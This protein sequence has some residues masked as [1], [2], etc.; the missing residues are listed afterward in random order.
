[1]GIIQDGVWSPASPFFDPKIATTPFDLA[2]ANAL[3]DQAGWKRTGDATRTKNG[4]PL[5]IE[6][7]SNTGSPDTDTQIELIREWWK[8]IG[9]DLERR[10]YDTALLFAEPQNGGI[11]YTGKF[12]VAIFA[13]YPSPGGDLSGI[14]GCANRSPH[15]QNIVDWCNRTAEAAMKRFLHSYDLETQRQ[16]DDV[17]QQQLVSDR[18]TFVLNIGEDVFAMNS[19]LHGFHPNVVTAFDDMMNVDI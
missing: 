14:Y 7:A 15:G 2:Q 18:P 13:W 17:V 16:A 6:F 8:S 9:V 5:T 4:K 11:L 3:L 10:N 12:D 1:L 19:D